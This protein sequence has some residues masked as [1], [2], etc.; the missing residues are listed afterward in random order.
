MA[1]RNVFDLSA[2]SSLESANLLHQSELQIL[3]L[4]SRDEP[5]PFELF[6]EQLAQSGRLHRHYTQNIDCRTNKLP[7]LS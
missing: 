7:A 6:M 1:S 4:A 3:E 2:Y 5:Q